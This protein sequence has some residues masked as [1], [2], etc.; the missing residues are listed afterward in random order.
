MPL[1]RSPDFWRPHP[2]YKRDLRSALFLLLLLG[3]AQLIAWLSPT[4]LGISTVPHYLPMH[5]LMETVSIVV[6]MMVFSVGWYGYR[7][8]VSGNLVIL[9]CT[10][11]AI[12]WLDMLH[13]LSYTGMPDFFTHNDSQKHLNYWMAA[14]ILA[15]GSLLVVV[16]RPWVP[17][18]GRASRYLLLGGMVSFTVLLN[19]LVLAHPHALPSWFVPGV[20]LTALKKNLEYLTIAMNVATLI[21]LWI[22]MREPQAYNAPLL[23]TAAA[24]MAMGEFFFTLYTTMVGAYNIMGHVYKVISYLLIYRA[25]VVEAIE[26]PYRQFAESQ[27]NLA[28]AVEASNTGLWTW[29]IQ[30]RSVYLSPI[31]KAQLGYRGEELASTPRAWVSLLHP[32]E[33]ERVVA[34]LRE[35]VQT[36]T[37]S[38][39][40]YKDQYRLRHRDGSYRWFL[41]RGELQVDAHGRAQRMS[42]AHVDVSEAHRADERFRLAVEVTPNPMIMSDEQ[43]RIV[44]A[45][46]QA[47]R[48]L[49]YSTQEL[50]GQSVQILIP[51]TLRDKHAVHM[52]SFAH[53]TPN[54]RMGLGRDLHARHKDGHEVPIEISLT[55][56]HTSEGRFVLASIVDLQEKQESDRHIHRLAHYDVLTELP[57]RLLLRDR[58]AQ[59]IS[60]AR[61][62]H[63]RIGVLFMDLDHFKNINDTL[64]HRIGDLLLLDIS[65]RL[66][67]L[68]R[69]HDTVSRIGG[70]EFVVLLPNTNADGAVHVAGKLLAGIAQPCAIEQHELMVTPSIGIAMYPDDGEDFDTLSQ[71]ADTAMYRAKQDGRNVYRFFT[72]EMQRHTSRALELENALRH[73]LKRDELFLHYQPQLDLSSGRIVGVEALL[74]WR[75]PEL[76]MV[77]PVEFIPIAESSGQITDIG[78]WVLRTATTQLSIW[79]AQGLPAMTVSV[80]LSAVQFRRS[81]LPEL[82]A[83]TLAEVSLPA[84]LLELELTESV[85]MLEPETAISVIDQLHAL[86]VGMAIDDF[87]TGYSSLSY[88]KQFKISRLKIDRSFVSDI[89]PEDPDNAIVNAVIRMAQSLGFRTIAEGV[90]TEAQRGYLHLQGCDEIQGYLI[91]RP[92]PAEEIPALIR[93]QR[94]AL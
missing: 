86:G 59:A 19:W 74:R 29:D 17:L 81:D 62:D 4:P 68:M 35:F 51:Q 82:V 57:N 85:A 55:T 71:R 15:A 13:T 80:N 10:F 78:T 47:S 64:G 48:L 8:V 21:V 33:R 28:M 43:H 76:G 93:G 94:P 45:N 91:S 25:L 79:L 24:V 37:A 89:N 6:A 65:K 27:K 72:Q 77:S 69:E 1:S 50:I 2:A 22:R 75:H 5:T 3:L 87:G 34:R 41:V 12:G 90:E 83:R 14:R 53:E 42:G 18:K 73:A 54:W 88:L 61:R 67:A 60:A 9:A 56:L 49:G 23:F 84:Q 66:R 26:T 36:T 39:R 52:H 20:G 31:W 44:L 11:F 30:D 16:L 38:S 7:Q 58:V 46:T 40:V 32:D 92:V 63:T 70:D